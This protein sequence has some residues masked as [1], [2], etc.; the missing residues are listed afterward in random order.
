MAVPREAPP[1]CSER[2]GGGVYTAVT[3]VKTRLELPATSAIPPSDEEKE[4]SRRGKLRHARTYTTST[5]TPTIH[6]LDTSV[7]PPHVEE[8]G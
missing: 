5:L 8:S 4:E 3:T 2:E 7:I 6:K 1:V